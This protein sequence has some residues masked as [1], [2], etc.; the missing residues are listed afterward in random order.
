[1]CALG[2]TPGWAT[3]MLPDSKSDSLVPLSHAPPNP[4]ADARLRGV[5]C[6][7]DGAVPLKK[8]KF[9]VPQPAAAS[10][11]SLPTALSGAGSS[12]RRDAVRAAPSISGAPGD[13]SADHPSMSPGDP[14]APNEDATTFCDS[15]A[16]LASPMN[17]GDQADFGSEDRRHTDD[18]GPG[19]VDRHQLSGYFQWKNSRFACYR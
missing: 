9:P 14:P 11:D 8:R 17:G 4:A 13:V 16:K 1:M 2:P 19:S 7:A 15:G 3:H 18:Q 12:S 10:W 6:G 5:W